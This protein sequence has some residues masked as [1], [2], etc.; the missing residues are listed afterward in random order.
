[1]I[2]IANDGYHAHYFERNAWANALEYSGIPN[3]LYDCKTTSAF[4]LLDCYNPSIFI[5]QLYNID[6]ATL[7]IIQE[8]PQ[9][10]VALRAGHYSSDPKLM[11]NPRVLTVTQEELSVLKEMMDTTGKPDFIYCH[12]LQEDIEMTHDLFVKEFNIPVVGIPMCADLHTYY[13][14]KIDDRLI[15][16]IAF[17]GG[18]WPYKGQIIDEY[19]TPLL[20]DYKYN[21]KIFGNQP[22]PHINQYC[23]NIQEQYV[24]DLFCS[25]S[26]CPNLSEPHSHEF[27]IDVNERA[28]KV[29]AAGG[30]CIMDNVR[31]AKKIFGNNVFFAENPNDFKNLIND[32]VNDPY[33]SKHRLIGKNF[34]LE[35]HSNFHRV[36]TILKNFNE[37]SL[38]KKVKDAYNHYIQQR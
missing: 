36:I 5:G 9:M 15:C 13:N 10:K 32:C 27:G 20:K 33:M 12:Y 38:V 23:G 19:L 14:G 2:V 25:A 6:K 37:S 29:L 8:S 22:W 18:Y 28:F 35:N 7:K 11:N 16:D 31:A 3:L 4:D 17:V 21:V 34:V 26:C 1:M 24:K 30:I